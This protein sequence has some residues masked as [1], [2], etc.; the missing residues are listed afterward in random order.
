MLSLVCCYLGLNKKEV[1]GAVGALMKTFYGS[2]F[3]VEQKKIPK[4]FIES[5]PRVKTGSNTGA[6]LPP[7]RISRAKGVIILDLVIS[8]IQ[9]SGNATS[10][11]T[12]LQRG[13]LTSNVLEVLCNLLT[14]S[15]NPQFNSVMNTTATDLTISSAQPSISSSRTS[16]PSAPQPSISSAP[17]TPRV[18]LVILSFKKKNVHIGSRL[19]IKNSCTDE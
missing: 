8:E 10:L 11:V 6:L 18:P 4:V 16:I 7:S 5:W 13:T 19:S 12:R 17:V 2:D 1:C 3:N 15:P 9:K 14:R